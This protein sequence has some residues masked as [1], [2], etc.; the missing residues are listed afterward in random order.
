MSVAAK[1]LKAAVPSVVPGF[2]LVGGREAGASSSAQGKQARAPLPM[3]I[4]E[5]NYS[6]KIR[7]AREGKVAVGERWPSWGVRV[8]KADCGGQQGKVRNSSARGNREQ[9]ISWK[10]ARS[11]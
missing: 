11:R 5:V 4:H 1:G 9:M 6:V 8:E 3:P 2:S 7:E 10:G